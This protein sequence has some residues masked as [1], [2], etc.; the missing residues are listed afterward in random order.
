MKLYYHPGACS[1]ADHIVL[2][3]TSKPY[4]VVRMSRDAMRSPAYLALNPGGKVPLLVDGD[5][6]L[7]E[8]AAILGYI[9]DLNPKAGLLGDGSPRERAEVMRWLAFINSE[10][11]KT[12]ELLFVPERYVVNP[13]DAEDLAEIARS[14]LRVHFERMDE[15]LEGRNWLIGTRSIADPYLF[16][17]TRWAEVTGVNLGDLANISEFMT[18]MYADPAVQRV[19]KKEEEPE[20]E[21][22]AA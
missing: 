10:V 4:D 15:R 1:L 21:G 7:T 12:F 13:D 8:N 2:E 11:H 14:Q 6:Q 19:L 17:V 5:F 18:R 3:W 9:A 22:T 20:A 16:V